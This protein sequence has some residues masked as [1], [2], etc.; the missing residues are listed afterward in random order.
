[1]VVLFHLTPSDRWLGQAGIAEGPAW[2]F[3]LFDAGHAGV[4]FFFVLSGFI[5]AYTYFDLTRERDRGFFAARAAR[6]YPL[7]LLGMLLMV[8]S[9]VLTVF[10][11]DDGGMDPRLNLAIQA[12]LCLSLV[13][14]WFPRWAL[15][16]NGPGWSLSVEAF[17]YACFPPLIR[18][19][20]HWTTPVLVVVCLAAV[21]VQQVVCG[22][23]WTWSGLALGGMQDVPFGSDEAWW[24][25]LWRFN[26]LLHLPE[27]ITGMIACVLLKRGCFS[28]PQLRLGGWIAGLVIIAVMI[29]GMV[30]YIL[31]NN[32]ALTLP[33]ALLILG[34]TVDSPL[35]R[36]FGSPVMQ[37]LGQ[38]SYAMYLLHIPILWY[39]WRFDQRVLHL[40]DHHPLLMSA[41]Y[42]ILVTGLSIA[43]FLWIEEP[44]RRRIRS[45]LGG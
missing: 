23:G 36:L 43:A 27:F 44:L 2:L 21:V 13:Q 35:S 33:C 5:L 8:P 11:I 32:G 3:H 25:D 10:K 38:A 28:R 40:G 34:L 16:G 19:L 18:S 12:I 24:A 22:V 41:I 30:P 7:Y 45:R 39:L 9:A 42:L 20:R 15:A 37:L 29:S 4:Q 31:L 6:I 1:M 14:A 26:P 17:F